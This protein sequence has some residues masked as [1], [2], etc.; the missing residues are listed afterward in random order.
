M[1][2]LSGICTKES[3]EKT[4]SKLAA[5]KGSGPPSDAAA[6]D[7]IAESRARHAG[8]HALDEM[9]VDIHPDHRARAVLAHE[10]LIDCA[11]A[12]ADIEHVASR[13]G[14]TFQ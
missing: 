12:A 2:A 10:Q 14:T 4:I 9:R 3:F 8:L 5:S 1:L 13:D 6:V 11:Q 7:A